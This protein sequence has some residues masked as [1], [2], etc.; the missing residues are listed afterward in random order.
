MIRST[1]FGAV[2]NASFGEI[3]FAKARLSCPRTVLLTSPHSGIC[4]RTLATLRLSATAGNQGLAEALAC[5]AELRQGWP[6]C[7]TILLV[8]TSRL[9]N[10]ATHSAAAEASWA[11]LETVRP[12]PPMTGARIALPLGETPLASCGL[13]PASAVVMA[14]GIQATGSRVPRPVAIALVSSASV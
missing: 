2:P 12:S 13:M 8:W 5:H 6:P 7:W 10:Q 14:S 3:S 9:L 1:D 11:Y 4:G